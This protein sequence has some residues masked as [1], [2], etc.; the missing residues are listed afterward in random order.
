MGTS[1]ST[2]DTAGGNRV[3]RRHATANL[4]R[5]DSNE[6]RGDIDS[7]RHRMDD[8]LD[9]LGDRLHPRRLLDDVMDFFGSSSGRSQASH[10]RDGL[11]DFGEN[12]SRT[13]RDN[14]MPTLLVGAGLA[15]MAL[16][17]RSNDSQSDQRSRRGRLRRY[18]ADGFEDDYA[19]RDEDPYLTDED[20]LIR[21]GGPSRDTA[22]YQQGLYVPET[23]DDEGN[24][25]GSSSG[26]KL[27]QAK[28]AASRAKDSVSG[29]ASSAGDSV[30][31]AASSAAE[32]AK[33]AADTTASA[34]SSAA[35][36]VASG[37]ASLGSGASHA[38][39]RAY[40]GSRRAG[41]SVYR[42]GSRSGRGASR[43]L[44]HQQENLGDL[45][46]RASE[47]YEQATEEY[48]LAVGAGC[49]ALGM[50]AG[51]LVPRTR[52]EDQWMGETSDEWIDDAWEAG[53]HA[54]ERG[55]QVA[56][57]TLATASDSA[58]KH[59]LTA[60]ELMRRGEHVA[61]K[62]VGSASDALAEEGLTPD[63]LKQE[64]KA[65]GKEATEK[66]RNEA[67]KAAKDAKGK[68]K[69][70]DPDLAKAADQGGKDTSG[71]EKPSSPKAETSAGSGNRN[72]PK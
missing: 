52:R 18:D 28:G 51:L 32:K 9:E 68:A 57:E 38:T 33:Q 37:A 24:Q 70:A 2:V 1:K 27:D 35:S 34:A 48:P 31:N 72:K 50:L 60:D 71:K 66:A 22:D 55:Q 4:D 17:S 21:A 67:G 15:W 65:V 64:V 46:E 56:A 59:G 61:D 12:L 53:Q 69:Q 25:Q 20:L 41:S 45:Y 42:Y 5:E 26:S 54:V 40:R 19:Y 23:Y 29:T 16:G 13:V 43:Q 36:K 11:A 7:T 3:D 62:V 58:Q 47:R 44:R 10:A 39:S 49:L 30:S 63:K 8:T 14:P 6:L